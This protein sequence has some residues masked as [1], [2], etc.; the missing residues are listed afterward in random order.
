MITRKTRIKLALFAVLALVGMSYLGFTYV[1][2]DRLVLGSGYQV[3][4]DFRDSG[5]IFVNAEVTYRGVAVGRVSDMEL[6]DDGVRVHLTIEPDTDPI[7]ARTAA[8]VATR[9]A[10]GEQYVDLRP[11]TDE[12]PYLEDG[13]VIPQDR[14]GI[15][16]P[17][18]Q[19][20]LNLDE[21]VG[22]IDEDNLRILVDELGQAFAGAGDDLGRL[23]D[24]GD[25]LLAR[26]QE[27]LPETL[28]LITD[29]RTVLDTQVASRSAIEQ[30]AA[31]LRTFTDTLVEI[32]PDLRGLVV[33]APDAGAQ[34]EQVVRDAGPGLGSLLR[35]VDILNDVTI[36]RLD[37]VEQLLVTYPDVVSGN[38][39]VVRR[40]ADGVMR[41]HF[42]FVLNAGDPHSCTTGYIPTSQL[43]SGSAVAN[44]DVDSVRC[45]VVNGV[46]PDP[47][48]GYDENGSSIRGEQN[49]GRSGG[50][51]SSGPQ[52]STTGPVPPL[53]GIPGQVLGQ[54]LSANPFAFTVG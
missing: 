6:I 41:S 39:T 36:P 7:P 20:L 14:T 46:D 53:S 27:S 3:A 30:W 26:A 32:D 9:S 54:L 12:G 1:G 42:G 10:V 23:I 40:D 5:G 48:D 11:D 45:D 44:A 29:G 51:R 18:E 2:L 49:I 33:N 22:S 28:R 52:G 43:P 16:V 35:N 31:E 24:N 13:A 4:A 50:T 19:L 37:G 17:V 38:F 34:L 21:L 15:P 25:L 47:G 8:F